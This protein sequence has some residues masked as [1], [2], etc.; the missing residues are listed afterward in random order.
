MTAKIILFNVK[1]VS[2]GCPTPVDGDVGETVGL[3]QGDQEQP[4]QD[5][6][7]PR[8]L[9]DLGHLVGVQEED[10]GRVALVRVTSR[11]NRS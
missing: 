6:Q 1:P 2:L 10:V 7:A 4:G 3:V 11:L 5:K 9:Q 8:Y